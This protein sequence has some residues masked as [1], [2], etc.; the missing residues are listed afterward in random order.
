MKMNIDNS[1]GNADG[2]RS[3]RSFHTHGLMTVVLLLAML[4]VGC[5][6]L[7]VTA[8]EVDA[9]TYGDYTYTASDGKATI[10]GY[11]GSGGNITTPSNIDGYNVTAIGERAF[12]NCTGLKEITIPSSVTTID[13]FAF[14]N[15]TGLE[16]V[17]FENG[18]KLT[19]IGV[20]AFSSCEG[21]TGITIPESVTSIGEGAFKS[22]EKLTSI[23]TLSQFQTLYFERF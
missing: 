16:T 6:V 7:S 10:T 9:D 14:Y 8:D 4:V 5:S 13:D 11:S 19:S 17:T 2:W 23:I 12:S 20:N 22:C 1:T 18:S 3:S 15:C 21:L